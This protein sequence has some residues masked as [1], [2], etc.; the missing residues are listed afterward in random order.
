MYDEL[1]PTRSKAVMVS[2]E[3]VGLSTVDE[4][5]KKKNELMKVP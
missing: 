3:E 1:D 2:D 5:T 4:G